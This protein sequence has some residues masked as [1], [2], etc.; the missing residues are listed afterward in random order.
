MI[1]SRTGRMSIPAN[2]LVTVACNTGNRNVY[3]LT[4]QQ[5]IMEINIICRC[6]FRFLTQKRVGGGG[7]VPVFLIRNALRHI[8]PFIIF[9]F[10]KACFHLFMTLVQGEKS[11]M[12]QG[13]S[14]KLKDYASSGMHKGEKKLHR[15]LSSS[16]FAL[17][18][19]KYFQSFNHESESVSSILQ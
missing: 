3:L 8:V 7:H 10:A 12:I 5:N 16:P 17:N 4:V 15:F 18:E 1:V 13:T 9:H 11:S 6:Y 19:N 14:G 2:K